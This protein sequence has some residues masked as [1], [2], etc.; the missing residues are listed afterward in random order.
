MKIIPAG[1]EV[2]KPYDNMFKNIE[3]VARVCY[4]SEDKICEGSAEKMVR[5][6]I[7]RRHEAMLEHESLIFVIP[8]FEDYLKFAEYISYL[9]SS[10]YNCMLRTTYYHR[11]VV[12]GNI[13]MWR[14]FVRESIDIVKIA[15]ENDM[16]MPI[17][18]PKVVADLLSYNQKWPILFDDMDMEL[19]DVF[20]DYEMIPI[21]PNQLTDLE[22]I[23]HYTITIKFTVD[24]GV[25]HEI[26]RHRVA[27]FAQE[28][29]RYVNYSKGQYGAEITVI[30]PCF[31]D[32]GT[33][34]YDAWETGC[35]AAEQAYMKLIELGRIAQEARDVLPTSV[36][37]EVVMTA[38]V[39]EWRHFFNLRAADSTGA[40]H[41]QMK[42]VTIPLL[43]ELKKDYPD[44]FVG[45][46]PANK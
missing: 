11:G 17:T 35:K 30:K 25:S 33:D 46:E 29:T 27:S 8:E 28:S 19:V 31:F 4:K 10:G 43:I 6:L 16:D 14:E 1:Y 40:A 42:E 21:T 41:P 13:R 34:A 18:I 32:E 38:A 26:V 36:K 37:T 44:F 23:V 45:I 20:D 39:S 22:K 15:Q 7:K 9:E 24:R 5:S 3:R 12:S 2:F